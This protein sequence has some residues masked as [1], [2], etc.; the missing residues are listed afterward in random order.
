MDS[1]L[2]KQIE[3]AAMDQE[4]GVCIWDLARNSV[5][6]DRHLSGVFDLPFDVS[7]HG[8]PIERYIAKVHSDDRPKVAK[9]LHDA[10]VNGR[11]YRQDYRVQHGNG[12]ILDVLAFGQ[13]FPDENGI[14]SQYIG[15]V[16]TSAQNRMHPSDEKL[17]TLYRQAED[18]ARHAQN[19]T[20]TNL[21][22]LAVLQLTQPQIGSAR[23]SFAVKH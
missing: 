13:C 15:V 7:Q 19:E 1:W 14:A 22:E 3:V 5:V 8:L 2:E 12:T 16:F 17:L 20:V 4:C 23:A 21:L 9:A 6:P 11:A 10:I 18:C